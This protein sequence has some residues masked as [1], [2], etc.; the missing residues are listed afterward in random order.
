VEGFAPRFEEAAPGVRRLRVPVPFPTRWVNVYVLGGGADAVLVDTGYPVP[1]GRRILLE[2]LREAELRP[3]LLLVTHAHPDHFG[4]AEELQQAFGCSVWMEARE[5]QV[6]WAYRPEGE[7]WPEVAAR[8]LRAGMPAERVRRTVEG[9]KQVWEPARPPR[10]DRFLREGEVLKLGGGAWEVLVT[11]GHAPA[12]VCLYE[13]RTGTLL[14]GDH[15]LARITPNIGLWPLGGPD[16]LA[17]FLESLQNFRTLPV[18]RVLPGHGDP[19]EGCAER[20]AELLA[21]HASRLEA[22]EAVL[23]TGAR[24]GYEVHLA[25]FGADL[26]PHNERFGLVEALAHLTYLERRGRVRAEEGDPV[27]YALISGGGGWS[28]RSLP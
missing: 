3:A 11:P 7:A 28:T 14:A 23:Q 22:V 25:L 1:E 10:V 8:F 27:R 9:G 5:L 26:D 20:V 2:A 21:H 18:R 13:K 19:Y 17:D 24:T 6:A 12:H 16:P 15:L 4:L